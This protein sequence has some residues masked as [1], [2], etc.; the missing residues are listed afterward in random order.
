M[1]NCS[2]NGKV[3]SKELSIGMPEPVE[4][5][6]PWKFIVFENDSK[7]LILLVGPRLLRFSRKTRPKYLKYK[8]FGQI[9]LVLLALARLMDD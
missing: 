9:V 5:W 4:N 1:N 2:L 8:M 6:S 7:S 3:K